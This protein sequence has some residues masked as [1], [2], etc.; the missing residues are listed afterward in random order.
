MIKQ[1]LHMVFNE[2]RQPFQAVAPFQNGNDPPL[3]M[4]VSHVHEPFHYPGKPF[5]GQIDVRHVIIPMGIKTGRDQNHF[6]FKELKSRNQVPF[7]K[8][9]VFIIPLT[10]QYGRVQGEAVTEILPSFKFPA[11]PG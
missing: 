9:P 4:F 1:N 5:G 2:L 11:V 3:G 10:W 8:G 6:R 7:N